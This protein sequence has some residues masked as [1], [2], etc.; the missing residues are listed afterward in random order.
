MAVPPCS[1][2]AVAVM[3]SDEG[4]QKLK[5]MHPAKCFAAD[6]FAQFKYIG[7]VG[8]AADLFEAAGV[9]ELD[10]GVVTLSEKADCADFIS[11][12]ATLRFWDRVA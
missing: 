6:A 5:K 3:A 11:E 9:T 4:V 1:Y 7:L 10:D 8:H 12:C 2:D